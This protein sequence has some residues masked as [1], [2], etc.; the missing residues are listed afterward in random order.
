MEKFIKVGEAAKRIGVSTETLRRW[1]NSGKFE[2]VRH[3]INNYRVYHESSVNLLMEEL[4]LEL[5]YN[6]EKVISLN[7][8]PKFK[9]EFGELFQYDAIEFLK[10]LEN[11]SVDLI[12]ADPPYNIKKAEWDTFFIPKSLC[13]MEHDVDKRS[14][15]RFEKKRPPYTFA[16]FQKFW[17]ILNG[18]PPVF[19]KGANGW[20]GFTETRVI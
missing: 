6:K 16:V 15:T 3:P 5:E 1:D 12:F 7:I 11:E 8:E 17:P 18:L 2:S 10:S 13:G 14:A 4:Q 19:F 20:C 9:T